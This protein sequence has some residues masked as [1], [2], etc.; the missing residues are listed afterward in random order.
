MPVPKPLAKEYDLPLTTV[1]CLLDYWA[2]NSPDLMFD[3]AELGAQLGPGLEVIP[4]VKELFGPEVWKML[5]PESDPAP[6]EVLPHQEVMLL[7]YTLALIRHLREKWQA[8][9]RNAKR[10]KPA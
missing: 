2:C 6:E 7:Q 9:S 5:H 1:S 4:V 3:W 8:F 10:A